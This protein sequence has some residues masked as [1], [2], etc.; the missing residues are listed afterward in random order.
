MAMK[1]LIASMERETPSLRWKGK[2]HRFD[3][4]EILVPRGCSRGLVEDG[5]RELAGFPSA[6]VLHRELVTAAQ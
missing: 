1:R 6:Q 3:G 2:P 4:K 5:E